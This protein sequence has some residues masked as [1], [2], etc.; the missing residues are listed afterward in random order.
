MGD[1]TKVIKLD[2]TVLITI[3]LKYNLMNTKTL[4]TPEE[5]GKHGR[6]ADALKKF[7]QTR[8]LLQ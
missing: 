6:C 4:L 1:D 3:T 7:T 2:E 5:Y 8:T